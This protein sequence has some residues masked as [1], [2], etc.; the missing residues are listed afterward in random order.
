MGMMMRSSFLKFTMS[1]GERRKARWRQCSR[2]AHRR[3]AKSWN[4]RRSVAT[5]SRT[6][7]CPPR[8]NSGM[9]KS[10]IRPATAGDLPEINAI[11]NHFVLAST[12][13]YQTEPETAEA[14]AAWLQAH[15]DRYP[16]TV[17]ERDGEIVGWASLSR[18]HVRA[19]YGKTVE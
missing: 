13:T 18:F 19:A 11:Y 9:A 12:C 7:F 6:A 3:V 10:T 16:I 14:R 1:F 4:R 2:F 5:P 17:A 8:Y 15:G